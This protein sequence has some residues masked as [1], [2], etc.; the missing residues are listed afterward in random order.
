MYLWVLS[1]A[2]EARQK[3]RIFIFFN[4]I[5]AFLASIRTPVF[6]Y[7][8]G[9]LVYYLLE[10]WSALET[11]YFLTVTSTTVGYGDFRPAS[12]LAR[13]FT[14]VYALIGITLVLDALSPLV[15]FL[16]GDWRE[17]L[18]AAVGCAAKV[19]TN[20]PSLTP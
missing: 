2:S 5:C 11:V 7:G 15:T 16:R 9:C 8:F 6:Y 10:G 19:D 14:C 1:L 3:I 17:R 18:L 13:A 12:T 4:V 20:D